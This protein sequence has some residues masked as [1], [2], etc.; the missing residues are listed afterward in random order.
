MASKV[1][2]IEV[3]D[4]QRF[5]SGQN[6]Y[7]TEISEEQAL[8][9]YSF[10]AKGIETGIKNG[11]EKIQININPDEAVFKQSAPDDKATGVVVQFENCQIDFVCN[12]YSAYS[13][14][15]KLE[16]T[17]FDKAGHFLSPEGTEFEYDE[18][19]NLDMDQVCE[20]VEKYSH[21]DIET[22]TFGGVTSYEYDELTGRTDVSENE[23]D[24]CH[25]D[26]DPSFFV[27]S[28]DS[29]DDF[30]KD[31]T[32]DIYYYDDFSSSDLVD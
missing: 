26:I 21:Y 30:D 31:I 1:T 13:S 20:L 7:K 17:I 15:E 19:R 18:I 6:D 23:S 27:D 28:I 4:M 2:T 12:K 10:W 14:E 9:D 5:E 24:D 29:D 8:K 16:S 25:A 11:A 22:N 32:N 3:I